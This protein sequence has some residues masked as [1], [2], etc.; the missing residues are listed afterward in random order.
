MPK[1]VHISELGDIKLYRRRGARNIRISIAGNNEIRVSLPFYVPYSTAL[2]FVTK[3][4]LWI[5][6]KL[7]PATVLKDGQLIGK[8]HRLRISH[9]VTIQ[10]I[11]TRV[12]NNE[13]RVSLPGNV[14]PASEAAQQ[15]VKRA[16]QRVLKQES[17]QLLPRQL[18]TL[19]KRHGY[20]FRSVQTKRL[21][22]RWGS[23]SQ[24]QDIVLNVFLMTLPWQLVDY[25]LIHELVHTKVLSHGP[26]FWE[27]FERVLPGAK[28]LRKQLRAYAPHF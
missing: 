9:D 14:D 23:C 25:V 11:R 8:Y 2:A 3:K 22:A 6:S 12:T 24:Q 10:T 20:H 21:K 5:A 13:L 18:E 7:R 4:H 28:S 17:E 1:T 27:E 16:A 19:A 26:D 15:Q